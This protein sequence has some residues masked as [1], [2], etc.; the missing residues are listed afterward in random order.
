MALIL[1]AGFGVVV[2]V[3]LTMARLAVSTFGGVVVDNSYVASQNF[4]RWLDQAERSRALGWSPE[5][6][7]N[8]DGRVVVGFVEAQTAP[9]TLIAVARHPLGQMPDVQL[10]FDR[11]ADGRFVSATSLPSGRWV[12]RMEAAAGED[13]WR[14][15]QHLQ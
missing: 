6:S 4:N 11:D 3:N 15:E 8:D 9:R 12:L 2:A 7:R 14:G 1:V 5:V 13:L 10:Q